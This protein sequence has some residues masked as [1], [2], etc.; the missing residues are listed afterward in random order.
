MVIYTMEL[1]STTNLSMK[2]GPNNTEKCQHCVVRTE[3]FRR[4]ADEA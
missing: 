2:I 4:S 1:V 3:L